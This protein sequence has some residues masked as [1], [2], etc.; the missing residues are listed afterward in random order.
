MIRAALAIALVVGCGPSS[1]TGKPAGTTN[2]P[3]VT[4]ERFGDVCK[5]DE[6]RLGVCAHKKAGSGFSCA[7]QH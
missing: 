3:V 2:D 4:C 5:I 6:S 1:S 7:S